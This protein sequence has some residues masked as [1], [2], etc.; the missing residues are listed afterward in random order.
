VDRER[1][2]QRVELLE[3]G[4]R[5]PGAHLAGVDELA[6]LV[7]AH[8]QRTRVAAAFALAVEPASDHELLPVA[9][10]DLHPRA[11]PA[12]RLVRRIEALG[13]DALEPA[14]AAGLEHR[15]AASLLERRRLPRGA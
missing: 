2:Q 8:E 5:E 11:A 7:V 14:G 1:F 3:R 9:V 6:V 10:L 13:H 12:P 15:L 4:V